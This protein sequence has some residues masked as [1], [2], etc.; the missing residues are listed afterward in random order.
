MFRDVFPAE[1]IA[2]TTS[3]PCSRGNDGRIYQ[4]SPENFRNQ[5]LFINGSYLPVHA[6][7]L[8]SYKITKLTD[9]FTYGGTVP[10]ISSRNGW[11]WRPGGERFNGVTV[12]RWNRSTFE[13]MRLES[14]FRLCPYKKYM[15]SNTLPPVVQSS[16]ACTCCCC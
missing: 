16:Q 4:P 7:H 12:A 14:K 8:P 5:P 1:Q 13:V 10:S 11:V 9:G 3:S 2:P 6:K 15:N